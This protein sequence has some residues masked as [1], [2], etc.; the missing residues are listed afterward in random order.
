MQTYAEE[1]GTIAAEEARSMAE[2]A[3]RYPFQGSTWRSD[4]QAYMNTQNTHGDLLRSTFLS[5]G[6]LHMP[7]RLYQESF[8]AKAADIDNGCILTDA[9]VAHNCEG[10]RLFFELDYRSR[11]HCLPGME[12][13]LLHVRMIHQTVTE[14]FPRLDRHTVHIATCDKKRKASRSN[15]TPALAWGIHLV[16]PDIVVT[17]PTM[18]LIAQLVDT[19][20]SNAFPT[21]PGVV[22]SASYRSTSATLRPCFSFKMVPCPICAVVDPRSKKRRLDNESAFREQLSNACSCF[23]GRVV[24]PSVYRYQGT[25]DRVGASVVDRSMN[26]LECLQAMSITPSQMGMFTPGFVRP[27]DMGDEHDKIPQ[28]DVVFPAERRVVRNFDRRKD[29]V[30]LPA[31]KYAEG[32]RV[33]REILSGVQPEF[34]HIAIHRVSMDARSQTFLV[35]VKGKGSRFC[36]YQGRCHQSNRVYFCVNLRHSRVQIH[37]FDPDCRR[38]NVRMQTI[39][40][41]DDHRLRMAFGLPISMPRPTISPI[42]TS[43]PGVAD[44]HEA[45]RQAW[46]E[47]R[48]AFMSRTETA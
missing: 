20:L 12:E 4:F 11:E 24:E 43:D 27:P 1:Y 19:R 10:I 48:K 47:K 40:L 31:Q 22:D 46:E 18:R 28:A 15:P 14:C 37:C 23:G 25:I 3:G 7:L 17:T 33:I 29:S 8:R 42:P 45:K 34:A 38:D 35:T 6:T 39:T 41:V 36:V 30:V 2:I 32:Y 16:F 5:G 44:T 9:E 21:W 26:T 13:A